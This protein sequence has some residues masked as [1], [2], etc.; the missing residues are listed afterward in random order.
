MMDRWLNKLLL[1]D[2]LDV[3][4]EM[5]DKC[6]DL[7]LTDPPYGIGASSGTEIHISSKK[8]SGNHHS[9]GN[10]ILGEWDS[11]RPNINVFKEI[12]RVSKNWI[13]WGGNY[14]TDYLPP[15]SCWIVWD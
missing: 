13:I 1:G 4:R 6:V 10:V 3:M 5:P 9:K 2:C 12:K 7:V 14:F 15:S 8:W 11:S